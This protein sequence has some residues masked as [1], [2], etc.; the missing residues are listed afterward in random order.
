MNRTPNR[1]A[2]AALAMLT[3]LAFGTPSAFAW[4]NQSRVH[5]AGIFFHN[6]PSNVSGGFSD[7]IKFGLNGRCNND[8]GTVDLSGNITCNA[9]RGQLGEYDYFNEFSGLQSHG[10]LQS[11]VFEPSGDPDCGALVGATGRAA[12]VKGGG[13]CTGA[14]CVDANG[15]THQYNFEITVVDDDDTAA[16]A[17]NHDAVCKVFVNGYTKT[18]SP[19]AD[20]DPGGQ[21]VKGDVEVKTTTNH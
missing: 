4:N 2:V 16:T 17:S 21:L 20:S 9:T 18:K 14:G 11:V 6:D 12:T 8:G 15:T 19:A 13:M 5:A 3:C 1:L 10:H 7:K